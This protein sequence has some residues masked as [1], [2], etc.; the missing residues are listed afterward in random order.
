MFHAYLVDLI[1][2]V[3]CHAAAGIALDAIKRLVIEEVAPTYEKPFSKYPD[4][5]PWRQQVLANIERVYASV[6]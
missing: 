3:K 4:Y 5:R 2:A 6:G 1:A